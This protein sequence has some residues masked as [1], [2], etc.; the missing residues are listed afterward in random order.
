LGR[1]RKANELSK[2]AIRTTNFRGVN[3]GEER[4]GSISQRVNKRKE[5]GKVLRERTRVLEELGCFL[6]LVIL[7]YGLNSVQAQTIGKTVDK[8]NV[9]EYKDLLIP[10]MLEAVK[11]GDFILPTANLGF[12]YK[13]SNQFL[14]ASGKNAGKFDVNEAGDL[15][16]KSTGKVPKFNIYGY[17]FPKID[18][19]DPR[20]A[21]KIIWNFNFQRYRLMCSITQNRNI[22]VGKEVGEERY[23]AGPEY[24]IFYQGRPPGQE[25]K[26]PQNFL[27]QEIQNV[28]EPMSIRG[29][30]TMSW[31]YFDEREISCFAYIPAIRRVR[32]TSGVSRSDPYM[33]SDGW[34]DLNYGWAGKN[35]S[36]KW[37]LVGE[38]TILVPFTDINKLV[39]E[40]E[41]NGTMHRKVPITKWGYMVKD[42]KGAPWAP[43]NI[44][45]VPR[46]VWVIEQMPKDPYYNWGLHINYVDK[47]TYVIWMKEVSDKAGVFRSWHQ[48]PLHYEEAPSGNNTVGVVDC[49]IQ[50]DEK[51]RHATLVTRQPHS[52]NQRLFAP[53]SK[54]GSDYFTMSN[55]LQL[56]K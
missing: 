10:A 33:G 53:I 38:K 32:Q 47:E 41:P 30:N 29:T 16:E 34:L 3:V 7:L 40:E 5:E 36:M 12:P 4:Q 28:T 31:D 17:P 35:R 6:V 14:A 13:H 18:P 9:Q 15:I 24:L 49:Y 45:Y 44:T 48:H 26:T 52:E 1:N 51:A 20:V 21:V 50:V 25:I 43:T 37:K 56:S 42:W 11:R 46:Q 23:I 2:N 39:A 8:S 55:F 22:W 19:K 27:S 54:L